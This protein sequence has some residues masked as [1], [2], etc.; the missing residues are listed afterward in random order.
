MYASSLHP[1]LKVLYMSGYADEIIGEGGIL[2]ADVAFIQKLF[3][4]DS[5]AGKVRIVLDQ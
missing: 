2:D 4:I 3:T 1:D 5:L